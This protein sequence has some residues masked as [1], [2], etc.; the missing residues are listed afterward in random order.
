LESYKHPDPYRPPTAPGG[1]KYERNLPV[2][3]TDRM[4]SRMCHLDRIQTTDILFSSANDPQGDASVNISRLGGE[5]ER[6]LCIYERT[7]QQRFCYQFSKAPLTVLRV[8]PG[9]S[10][11]STGH[12]VRFTASTPKWFGSSST[13]ILLFRASPWTISPVVLHLIDK[14]EDVVCPTWC[15]SRSLS[16]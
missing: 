3:M 14:Y 5:M 9:C 8:L 13:S 1:S 11:V 16:L 12:C 4:L 7:N 10:A 2:P 15:V 6:A